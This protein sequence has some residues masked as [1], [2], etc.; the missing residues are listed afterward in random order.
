MSAAA[1]RVVMHSGMRA[2]LQRERLQGLRLSVVEGGKE[3]AGAGLV[4]PGNCNLSARIDGENFLVTP[5]GR[6]NGRLDVDDLFEIGIASHNVPGGASNEVGMHRAI[7]SRFPAI[8]AVV[9]LHP[10][11]VLELAKRG[12]APDPERLP[13]GGTVLD[14]VSWIDDFPPGTRS[15]AEE[16]A[17]GIAKAPSLVI[18]AHG[19]VTVGATV[20][21]AVIR[22][23]RLERLAVMTLGG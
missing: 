18:A 13:D 9:H 7:Y 16:V 5:T 17:M 10:E 12:Y 1:N 4:K 8:H 23:I 21:Q 11:K 19:A 22:M 20:E 6:D 15:L 2:A 14:L 3:L